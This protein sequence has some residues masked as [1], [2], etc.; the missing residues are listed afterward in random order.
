MAWINRREIAGGAVR[1]DVA[2]RLPDGSQRKRTFQRRQDAVRYR[3]QLA[4]AR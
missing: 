2:W 1:Y 3:E 4:A